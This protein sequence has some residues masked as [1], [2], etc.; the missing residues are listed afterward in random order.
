[1]LINAVAVP[2]ATGNAMGPSFRNTL[3]AGDRNA[4]VLAF[5][6][7]SLER[8]PQRGQK[9][10]VIDDPI[11]SL[12]EH[13]SLVT[14]QEMRRRLVDGTNPFA[15]AT[16][17]VRRSPPDRASAVPYGQAGENIAYPRGDQEGSGGGEETVVAPGL[18]GLV[19]VVVGRIPYYGG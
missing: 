18:G 19:L 10:V 8:D 3:S 6:F 7:A 13:R 16:G 11:S 4:L 1:M 14:I 2:L 5:F 12:D 9:I 15:S 17:S